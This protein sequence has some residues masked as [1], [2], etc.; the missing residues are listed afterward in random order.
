MA[1]R[2][3]EDFIGGIRCFAEAVA[4]ATSNTCLR[5]YQKY[6]PTPIPALGDYRIMQLAAWRHERQQ[7]A[8]HITN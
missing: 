3:P 6:H 8:K 5:H 7:P 2:P 1:D 4:T